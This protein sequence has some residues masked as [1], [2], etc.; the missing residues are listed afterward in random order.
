VDL[1]D[2]EHAAGPLKLVEVAPEAPWESLTSGRFTGQVVAWF[3]AEAWFGLTH[4]AEVTTAFDAA[5]AG[6]R[7]DAQKWQQ[8][9]LAVDPANIATSGARWA[10]QAVDGVREYE[11]ECGPTG[12]VPPT[13]RAFLRE[14]QQSR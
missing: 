10:Q 9:G 5:M 4:P 7:E 14:A 8:H 2:Q 12:P 3:A 13:L 6:A 1:L 11:A